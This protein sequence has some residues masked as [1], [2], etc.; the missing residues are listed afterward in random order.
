MVG[1]LLSYWGGLFSGAT[2]VSGRV[3]VQFLPAGKHVFG[4]PKAMPWSQGF[5][6][7]MGTKS[8]ETMGQMGVLHVS[9]FLLKYQL[10]LYTRWFKVTFWFPSWR[11]LSPLKGHLTIPKRSQR[12]A[13]YLKVISNN[14]PT[15]FESIDFVWS[16]YSDLTRPHPKWW[17]SIG[18][19]MKSPYFREI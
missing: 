17:F 4:R 1:I 3:N 2:L 11:S 13:R 12:I 14:S 7:E 5:P 19:P 15:I 16:N 18:N 8:G 6:G 9:L 10:I